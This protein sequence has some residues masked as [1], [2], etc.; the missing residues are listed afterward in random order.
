MSA[1][2]SLCSR[3]IVLHQG[4]MAFDGGVGKAIEQYY[5]LIRT[6]DAEEV[7]PGL[8][9]PFVAGRP[10]VEDTT[11]QSDE[12]FT[13]C[14][15]LTVPPD[16]TGFSIFCT[17][18]DMDGTFVTQI[19]TPS[20]ELGLEGQLGGSHDLAITF[21]PLWLTPGPYTLQFKVEFWGVAVA[22]RLRSPS[23]V[24]D[25]TGASSAVRT[26]LH[27]QASWTVT[28]TPSR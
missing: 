7:G 6:V 15:R 21:P 3:G 17:L 4:E 13:L 26:L 9:L 8:E 18:I 16:V 24:L 20:T 5:D 23:V 27:P 12:P 2:R 1:V 19:K 28:R 25:F 14:T 10:S 22:T 11:V